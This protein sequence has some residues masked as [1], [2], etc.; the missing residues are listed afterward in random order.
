MTSF[1]LLKCLI[2]LLCRQ[3][4]ICQNLVKEKKRQSSRSSTQSQSV[5]K[6]FK[7]KLTADFHNAC[8]ELEGLVGND[9]PL[10]QETTP[11][12]FQCD[13]CKKNFASLATLTSHSKS[14]PDSTEYSCKLCNKQFANKR[15]LRD[16]NRIFHE[17]AEA[18]LSNYS[19]SCPECDKIFYKKSNLTSHMLRH[20]RLY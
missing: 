10:Y 18:I 7:T 11:P 20:S 15:N 5:V 13:N 6:D 3:E 17:S 2:C 1:N 8:D 4:N 14:C 19:L 16:H 9:E 12:T